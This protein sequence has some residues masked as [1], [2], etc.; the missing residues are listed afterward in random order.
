MV[1]KR[2][3]RIPAIWLGI[4]VFL[5]LL[6]TVL[7]MHRISV[8]KRD[9]R[10]EESRQRVALAQLENERE[11]LRTEITQ[12]STDAYIENLARSEY[13]YLKPDEIRYEIKNPELLEVGPLT[14]D[15]SVLLDGR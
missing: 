6:V 11:S 12:A 9:M 5:M 3:Y 7:L 8:F 10:S 1:A 2:K 4:I 14:M 13:G 15:F